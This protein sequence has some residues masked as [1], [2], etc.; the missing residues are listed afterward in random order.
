MET[1]LPPADKSLNME[2][3]ETVFQVGGGWAPDQE[4]IWV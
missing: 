4:I 3:E 2:T 1:H